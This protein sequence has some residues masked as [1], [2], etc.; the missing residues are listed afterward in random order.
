MSRPRCEPWTTA[1]C[2]IF[3]ILTENLTFINPCSIYH[4]TM[5]TWWLGKCVNSK[6][7]V[8][9]KKTN[10]G[11]NWSFFLL[12]CTEDEFQCVSDKTCIPLS[13]KCNGNSECDDN[14]DEEGC[15]PLARC[16]SN[17]QRCDD[18]RGCYDTYRQCDGVRDCQDGTDERDCRKLTFCEIEFRQPLERI[19]LTQIAIVRFL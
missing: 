2:Y 1:W 3:K 15:P 13:Y 12:E 7:W 18:G 11:C 16:A 5:F 19:S 6:T 8:V 17:Q 10:G 14:S 4:T 9:I